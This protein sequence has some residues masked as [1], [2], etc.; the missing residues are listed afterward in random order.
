MAAPRNG[1]MVRIRRRRSPSAVAPQTRP[2]APHAAA[3]HRDPHNAGHRLV[4]IIG[5]IHTREPIKPERVVP[6]S[7]AEPDQRRAL[8]AGRAIGSLA[9]TL[10]SLPNP[11]PDRLRRRLKIL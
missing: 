7:R 2:A 1:W 8:D 6:L 3:G 5:L 11:V 4:R 9:S 10:V